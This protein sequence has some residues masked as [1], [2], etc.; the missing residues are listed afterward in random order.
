M[1][2][3]RQLFTV[4][5]ILPSFGIPLV[6]LIGGCTQPFVN[7]NVQVD[8]CQAGG[9]MGKSITDI[10]PPGL[11]NNGPILGTATD[12]Y[13]AY[14]ANTSPPQKITDHAHYCNAGTRK[15]ASTPGTCNA[16]SCVVKYSPTDASHGNCS[17]AC[18]WN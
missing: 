14:V 4:H 13:G 15:C 16:Q 5:G 10:S 12:A 8:A 3:L 11:C 1:R 7:V 2:T 6:L 17:C 18:Q 9:N